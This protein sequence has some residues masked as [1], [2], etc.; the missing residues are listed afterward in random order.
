MADTRTEAEKR[1]TDEITFARIKSEKTQD[2]NSTDLNPDAVKKVD[3]KHHEPDQTVT[4]HP[5]QL[6]LGFHRLRRGNGL[7]HS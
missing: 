6:S 4:N 3:L 7:V 1:K 2:R 5:H